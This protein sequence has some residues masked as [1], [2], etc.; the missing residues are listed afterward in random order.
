MLTHKNR[1]F[2]ACDVGMMLHKTRALGMRKA[3]P[4]F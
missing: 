4:T 1:L 2:T 3:T